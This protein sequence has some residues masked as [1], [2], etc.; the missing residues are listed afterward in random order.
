MLLHTSSYT[1]GG[2]AGAAGHHR[3][4]PACPRGVQRGRQQRGRRGD[5]GGDR[6]GRGACRRGVA[7][8]AASV[9]CRRQSCPVAC[10]AA[11]RCQSVGRAT[12]ARDWAESGRFPLAPDETLEGA[13]G[14]TRRPHNARAV[15]PHSRGTEGPVSCQA[16]EAHSLRFFSSETFPAYLRSTV[17]TRMR[18]PVSMKRGTMI[19]RPV[20]SFAGFHVESELPR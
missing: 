12:Q 16:R 3:P 19:S 6:G 4:R 2:R 18:S 5:R 11:A 1:T 9:L 13:S 20:S 7:G 8:D 14:E 10:L 17:S 15:T